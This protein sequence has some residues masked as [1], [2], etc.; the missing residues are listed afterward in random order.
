MIQT[1]CKQAVELLV[2]VRVSPLSTHPASLCPTAAGGDGGA[3]DTAAQY[4]RGWQHEHTSSDLSG[5]DTHPVNRRYVTRRPPSTHMYPELLKRLDDSND[6]VRIAVTDT[7]LAYLACFQDDYQV[8]LY[9]PISRR[10]TKACWF[11]SMTLT[12][13]IQD[14]VLGGW[15]V[16]GCVCVRM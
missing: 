11:I 10:C 16:C 3:D 14:A 4:T 13:S 15:C 2:R 12:H 5:D 1:S 6:D 7:W 8:A 9:L